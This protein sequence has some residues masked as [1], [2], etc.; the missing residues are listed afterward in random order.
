MRALSSI[1]PLPPEHL[2][3]DSVTLRFAT[4]VPGDAALGFVPY[5]HFRILVGG[6]D[7]GHINLRVGD[8]EHVLR[9]AGHIGFEIAAPHRGHRYALSACRALASF[10]RSLSERF[11]LTCDPDNHPSR[12]TLELLGAAFIDEVSVPMHDPHYARGSRTKLR[13]EWTP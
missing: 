9:S 10:A 4:L 3:G 7:V 8:T 12:R 6:T 1:P 13:F 11:I 5:Y 2:E